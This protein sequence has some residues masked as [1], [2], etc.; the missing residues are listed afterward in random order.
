MNDTM[1][2]SLAVGTAVLALALAAP[3]FAG[4]VRSRSGGPG[5]LG[6]EVPFDSREAE[7]YYQV[8]LPTD[9]PEALRIRDGIQR[10]HA[11]HEGAI[12]L[13]DAGARSADPRVRELARTVRDDHARLDWTLRR[14][15][16]TSRFE[17]TG[18][19]FQTARQEALAAAREV[20]EAQGPDLD[21]AFLARTAELLDRAAADVDALVP[22]ARE[23]RRQVLTSHLERERKRLRAHVAAARARTAPAADD[24]G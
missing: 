6:T 21:A 9:T 18:P 11:V 2:R 24:A 7:Q 19:A 16:E 12:A 22:Q 4:G 1:R 20:Q 3:A 23:A 17:R 5:T 14:Y 10:L 8:Y 13:A 15:F